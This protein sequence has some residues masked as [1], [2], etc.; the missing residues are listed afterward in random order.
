MDSAA[1][2]LVDAPL[3]VR[4]A[5]GPRQHRRAAQLG[6]TDTQGVPEG[7]VDA[8]VA[9]VAVDGG[10]V[11]GEGGEVVGDCFARQRMYNRLRHAATFRCSAM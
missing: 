9:E 4:P 8:L 5:C 1:G 2:T 10:L 3:H 11:P 6:E 7:V